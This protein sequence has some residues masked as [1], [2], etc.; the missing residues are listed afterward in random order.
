MVLISCRKKST[1]IISTRF[2]VTAGLMWFKIIKDRGFTEF[3]IA[4]FLLAKKKQI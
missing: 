3:V 4:V 2:L 1:V